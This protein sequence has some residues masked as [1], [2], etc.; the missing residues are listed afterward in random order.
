MTTGIQ[1]DDNKQF[2]EALSL[3]K[4]RETEA[5]SQ[6]KRKIFEL[7]SAFKVSE[8]HLDDIRSAIVLS[9]NMGNEIIN[10]QTSL[11]MLELI[12]EI[13]SVQQKMDENAYDILFSVIELGDTDTLNILKKY[14]EI[15]STLSNFEEDFIAMA[16]EY[17]HDNV[18][19]WISDLKRENQNRR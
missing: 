15:K 1:Q 10:N 7:L 3:A 11:N 2:S 5:S 6:G 8:V 14:P 16:E 18:I 9:N 12:F 17:F 19:D 4:S 13:P